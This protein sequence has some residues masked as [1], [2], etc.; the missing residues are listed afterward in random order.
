MRPLRR[1]PQ[2]PSL[3]RF[4]G[5]SIARRVFTCSLSTSL[6]AATLLGAASGCSSLGLGDPDGALAEPTSASSDPSSTG[7]T[8]A[9]P[10]TSNPG[11]S[12]T[13]GGPSGSSPVASTP[14]GTAIAPPPSPSP[15]SCDV[16]DSSES[17]LR[18]LSRL[19]YQ[20][21]LKELFQRNTIPAVET[22]PQDSDFKGFRTLAALQGVTTEH[23]RAYQTEADTLSRELWTEPARRDAVLGCDPEAAQC[24]ESFIPRFGR[25][26]YRRSLTTPEVAELVALAETEGSATADRFSIVIS[27]ILSSASFLFRVEIGDKQ[28]GLSTLTGEELASRLS[29]ALIGRGPSSDLLD[30]GA[31][32]ELLTEQGLLTNARE[33]LSD[34]RAREFFDAFFQ[35]WLGFEKMRAP[36]SPAPGFNDSILESMQEETTRFLHEYAWQEG[37]NF[38][39]SLTANHSYLRADLAEFYDLPAPPADGFVEFPLN[40]NRANSGLLSHAA[41]ISAKNDG[42]RIAHRGAWVQR[43]F[44]CLNLQVP[45]ALLDSIAGELDGLTYQQMLDRRNSDGNCSGCHAL[46]DPIG[47]GFSAYDEIGHFDPTADTRQYGIVPALPGGN[48]FSTLGELAAQLRQQAG[49]VDCITSRVFLYADGR[50]PTP[51]DGCA[52]SQATARF[53][54]DQNRFASLLEG[55]VTAPNFRLR[56]A[57]TTE[58]VSP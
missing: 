31:R 21:T 41:L 39:D 42:D 58:E 55:L 23:L 38:L 45:T 20:L 5:G 4:A 22:V 3:F 36:K 30:R 54:A 24:L 12:A 35:Q 27:A 15:A 44:Q 50:E 2:R 28:E 25:L 46:I 34:A 29:F 32:G 9:A 6:S 16:L 26:A 19:E 56:R 13:Q 53:T 8:A 57:P 14:A 47:V 43:T 18:R 40:H 33:L 37:A 49:I 10:G 1:W 7:N 17:V 11:S 48:E 52:L 51:A